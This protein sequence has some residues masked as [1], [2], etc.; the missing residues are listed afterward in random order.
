MYTYLIV[1]LGHVIKIELELKEAPDDMII[2]STPFKLDVTGEINSTY[3][4]GEFKNPRD[5]PSLFVHNSKITLDPRFQIE[6]LQKIKETSV[7]IFKSYR[8]EID[9]FTFY[10]TSTFK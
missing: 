6:K 8:G 5:K 9:F 7:H 1:C 2:G 10:R 3:P 4:D